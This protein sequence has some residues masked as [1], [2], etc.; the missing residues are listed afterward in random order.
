MKLDAP[1]LPYH[2]AE[3]IRRSYLYQSLWSLEQE[4][5]FH[6]IPPPSW[7]QMEVYISALSHDLNFRAKELKE[8]WSWNVFDRKVRKSWK[9]GERIKVERSRMGEV[10]NT[11]EWYLIQHRHLI[12]SYNA[13]H[14]NTNPFH[15]SDNL[16]TRFAGTSSALTTWEQQ[17]TFQGLN[18]SRSQLEDALT[19]LELEHL[20]EAGVVFAS[21]LEPDT[22]NEQEDD[23][24]VSETKK[25]VLG[26][27]I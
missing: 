3:F 21:H 18:P 8:G 27:T 11:S 5:L 1:F 20:T 16:V 26:A 13:S 24:L 22:T 10:M 23:R 15:W 25:L 12:K 9:M 6:A 4:R 19:K 7:F 14:P 17:K 2:V